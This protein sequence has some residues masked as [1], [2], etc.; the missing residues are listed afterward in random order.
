M[1]LTLLGQSLQL[2]ETARDR[3]DLRYKAAAGCHLKFTRSAAIVIPLTCSRF[4]VTPAYI[5]QRSNAKGK[6][7]E[8]AIPHDKCFF[9]RLL[10][11]LL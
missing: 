11:S 6:Q 5:E 4:V 9:Q 3:N 8:A 2:L 1:R 10:F 7:H